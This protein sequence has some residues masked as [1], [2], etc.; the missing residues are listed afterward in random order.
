MITIQRQRFTHNLNDWAGFFNRCHFTV[1]N[2]GI[3]SKW[4]SDTKLVVHL[5]QKIQKQK[6]QNASAL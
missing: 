6:A 1:T 3:L 4:I 2:K 5:S